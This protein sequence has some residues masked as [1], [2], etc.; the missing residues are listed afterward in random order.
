MGATEDEI[1]RV[2]QEVLVPLV[3]ADG[4]ELYLVNADENLV[5]LHL[6]GRYAGCPGNNLARR[7]LIEPA[8]HSVAPK[9][10]VRVTSG[11][12]VPKG[13]RRLDAS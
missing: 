7:Q 2:L 13:A 8:I 5:A 3:Q 12:L 1:L 6:A 11:A 4:G 9:A 10:E